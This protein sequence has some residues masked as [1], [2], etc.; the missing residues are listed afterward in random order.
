[1]KLGTDR[2]HSLLDRTNWK[3]ALNQFAIAFEGRLA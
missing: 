1:M 3:P 2:L